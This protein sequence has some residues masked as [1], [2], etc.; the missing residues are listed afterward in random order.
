MAYLTITRDGVL[1]FISG[2]EENL[3]GVPGKGDLITIPTK[4]T[5]TPDNWYKL[6]CEADFSERKFVSFSIS[7]LGVDKTINL[8]QYN[9]VFPEL[10]PV[11]QRIIFL[12]VGGI[13][14]SNE[15]GTEILFADDV[16]AGIEVNGVYKVVF[17]DGFENQNQILDVPDTFTVT[18]WAEKVWHLERD[19]AV[20]SIV[21][22]PVH[23]GLHS[24]L[25]NCAPFPERMKVVE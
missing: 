13:K 22:S 19:T 8:T 15:P 25:I 17:S 21:D 16:E 9:I 18:D 1:V 12:A 14:L 6:R 23:S 7:G 4:V 3:N 2:N 20:V 10:A 11:T 24:L 5:L